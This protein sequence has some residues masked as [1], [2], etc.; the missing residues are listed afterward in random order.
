MQTGRRTRCEGKGGILRRR[1]NEGCEWRRVR[2]RGSAFRGTAVAA[3]D[4]SNLVPIATGHLEAG[5]S[6]GNVLEWARSWS[7][8]RRAQRQPIR[9]PLML[10]AKSPSSWIPGRQLTLRSAARAVLQIPHQPEAH[11]SRFHGKGMRWNSTISIK[12]NNRTQ[13]GP[14]KETSVFK[15][16]SDGGMRP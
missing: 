13:T 14:H 10:C 2:Q 6:Y 8:T 5:C 3:Q 4:S 16:R 7:V 15:Y 12:V 11:S 1:R 9:M